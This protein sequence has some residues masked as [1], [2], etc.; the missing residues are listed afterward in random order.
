MLIILDSA[1]RDKMKSNT[2]PL[3]QFL[4]TAEVTADNSLSRSEI[5][6]PFKNHT[7]KITL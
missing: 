2:L 3:P 5:V 6:E 7:N 1:G 4:P